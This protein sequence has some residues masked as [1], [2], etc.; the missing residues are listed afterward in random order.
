MTWSFA[1][2]I[3]VG[4]LD[5]NVLVGPFLMEPEDDTI[6]VKITQTSPS[7]VWTYSYG[8]LTWRTVQGQELGTIKVYGDRDSGT[9]DICRAPAGALQISWGLH[10]HATGVQPALDFH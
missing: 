2:Q 10:I 6:W 7:D 4:P 3:D 9:L 1:G 8:L 5:K